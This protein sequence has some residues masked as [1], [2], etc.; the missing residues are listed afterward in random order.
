M[1]LPTKESSLFIS[2]YSCLIGFAAERLGGVAGI[3]SVEDF[4]YASNE[5]RAEARDKLLS[6]VTLIDEFMEVN[7]YQFSEKELSNL[8]KFEKF[9]SGKF[10]IE[11]DLKNYTIF[12]NDNDPPKAYGVLG[13]TDEIVEMVL[14]P[15][16]TLV[17]AVLLPWKGQ[18]ICDGLILTYSVVLGRGITKNLKESYRQAKAQGIVTSLDSD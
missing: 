12:L 10:F 16:P 5:A 4:L 8:L 9:V 18:I 6:N 13:L 11:R 15:L 14:F 2:L 7:P 17:S 3:N 1:L